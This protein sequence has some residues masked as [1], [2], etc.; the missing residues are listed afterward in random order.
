M[1]SRLRKLAIGAGVVLVA[2][3]A[4]AV[5][6]AYSLTAPHRSVVGDLPADLAGRNIT[7][8]GAEGARLSGW[9]VPSDH[10]TAVV[11]LMHGVRANRLQMLD[12]ARF[13]HRA[14]YSVLLY[15]SRAQGESTG[16]R[17]TF[18]Y[19]ES[20]DARAA[21]Q[22]ARTLAGDRRVAIIGVS[23]GGAAAILAKPPLDVNALVLESV[24]PDIHRAVDNR[25]RALGGPVGA[26]GTPVLMAL[27]QPGCCVSQLSE[28]RPIDHVGNLTAPKLFILMEPRISTRRWKNRWS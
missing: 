22:L 13:L 26:M 6:G 19:L 3:T 17:I 2:G 7:F 15:D 28:L 25:L 18:G 16:D 23:M 4:C 8:A 12:R 11:V 9:F 5:A 24:Y 21:I 10:S 14:G 20:Q 27:F 1:T